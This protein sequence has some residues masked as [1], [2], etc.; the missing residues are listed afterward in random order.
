MILAHWTYTREEWAVFHRWQLR[1]KSILHYFWDRLTWRHQKKVP[2]IKITPDAVWTNDRD[3]NFAEG[4]RHFQRVN[5]RD[6]GRLNVMEIC[7]ED[8]NRSLEIRVPIPKG[9]LREAIEV[10]EK[11]LAR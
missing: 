11:L 4:E 7:Y 5:I 3:E 2:E 8:K 9:K 10:Q 6:A 1:R